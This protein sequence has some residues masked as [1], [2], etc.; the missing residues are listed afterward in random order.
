MFILCFGQFLTTASMSCVTPFLPLYL[1][2]LGVA[3]QG[4]V[5]VWSGLIYGANLL[6]AFLFSPV[7]GK[8]ADRYGR[9]VML[10]RSAFGMAITFTLMGFATSPAQLLLLRLANGIMS[11]F[12]PAAIALTATNTPQERSGYALGILHSSTVGGSVCGPLLGAVLATQFGFSAVFCITGVSLFVA[13]VIVIFW[14]KEKFEKNQSTVKRTD[15]AQDFR[16]IISQKPVASLFVSA[17][18]VKAAMIGT[19]PL[20]PLYV[21]MLAPDQQNVVLLTGVATAALGIA[22]MLSAPQLGKLGDRFG[23]HRVFRLAVMGAIAFMVPQAFVQQLPQFIAL[24][25]CTGACLGGLMPSL[26]TLIRHYAPKGMESR[27]YSYFHCSVFLGG[28]VGSSGM[29]VLASHFGLP[30]V[31]LCSAALLAANQ[32]WLKWKVIPHIRPESSADADGL[33]GGR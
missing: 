26:N 9:K 11:G 18:L 14:V 31:F 20:I 7:W 17:A 16:Q 25:F 4:E 13:A 21:Q 8:F 28:I 15:F 5:L 1:Q 32:L 23:T 19:V 10:V 22:N 29:G 27:T 3:D 24:R 30:T 6:T 12:A 33:G 2:E